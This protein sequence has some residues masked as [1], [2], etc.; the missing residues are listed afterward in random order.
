MVDPISARLAQFPTQIGSSAPAGDQP[1]AFGGALQRM[2]SA[3]SDSSQ[4]ANEAVAGMISG[5]GDVHTAMIAL[6][7]AEMTM[8][9]TV[10]VKNKLV[11]AYQDVMRMTI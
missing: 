3:V 5:T 10:Q 2:L 4:A 8:E 6:Q 11:Q 9:L 7:K 1:G